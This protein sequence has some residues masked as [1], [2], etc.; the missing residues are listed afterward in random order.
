ML[1]AFLFLLLCFAA[2]QSRAQTTES[3]I[4]K[5]FYHFEHII[6]TNY[7]DKPQ[8]ENMA[9]YLARNASLYASMDNLAKMEELERSIKQQMA[10]NGGELKSINVKKTGRVTSDLVY[11]FTDKDRLFT[12]TRLV[13]NYLVEEAPYKIDWSITQDTMNIAGMT[14][15]K[16]TAPFRGRNWTAWFNPEM[17]FQTGPWKLHG[18]PGLIVEARDDREDVIF[19]FAGFEVVKPQEVSQK[20]Q[21]T[22]ANNPV[23]LKKPFNEFEVKLPDHTVRTTSKEFAKLFAARNKDPQGF[24]QTQLAGSGASVTIV[25]GEKSTSSSGPVIKMNNPIELSAQ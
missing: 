19:T 15:Y 5:A 16:A 9:L 11:Y 1:K 24:L 20:K 4:A 12:E 25:K 14:C 17:P 23:Q 10:E 22:D 2:N 6:D 7:R 13:T 8:K 3:V 21:K 18:L